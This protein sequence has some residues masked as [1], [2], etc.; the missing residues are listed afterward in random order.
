MAA[1]SK[2]FKPRATSV[3]GRAKA[4]AP[5]YEEQLADLGLVA[6]ETVTRGVDLSQSAKCDPEGYVIGVNVPRPTYDS[7]VS[8]VVEEHAS[9]WDPPGGPYAIGI[10]AD[11]GRTIYR[12]VH[13][14]GVGELAHHVEPLRRA[15]FDNILADLQHRRWDAVLVPTPKLQAGEAQ[16]DGSLDSAESVE[17][18]RTPEPQA[19][20][21]PQVHEDFAAAAEQL[22]V[23][24]DTER[25]QVVLARLGQ[26][27]FRADL[28]TA[29][30][31]RC[32]L[33]ELKFEPV[34]RASHIKP[35]RD[36]TN[37][38]R[39]DADNGLLL[40]ADIDALFD[41][42]Y[43]TFGADGEL[44]RAAAIPESAVQA[45]AAIGVYEQRRLPES[46]LTPGRRA[47]LAYHRA[48]VFQS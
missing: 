18:S 47:F 46:V 4:S 36:S 17:P 23:L 31:G 45:L 39:L 20:L 2:S 30:G 1:P 11:D 28:I 42:G 14:S 6:A 3:P 37:I 15:G 24:S 10:V 38:E 19:P 26:G 8:Q 41:T 13:V 7:I 34:L 43:I 32:G 22:K 12:V 5:S 25:E 9:P 40:R 35:W 33:T 16:E 27:C 29:F 48:S 21:A 44:L